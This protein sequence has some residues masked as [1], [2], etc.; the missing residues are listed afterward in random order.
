[1]EKIVIHGGKRL[2]GKIQI[3]GAKNSVLP[4]MAASLLTEEEVVVRNV[5]WLG[6][7]QIMAQIMRC[8][9]CEAEYKNGNLTLRPNAL[10][11]KP[12]AQNQLTNEIRY[13]LHFI[14][15][16]LPR[17]DEV[18][19][20]LPGGCAIGTR[21]LDSHILG[22]TML[23]AK[24]DVG[25]DYIR[26]LKTKLEGSEI[27]LEYP[28]VGATENIIIA[29]CLAEGRTSLE[30]AA[31]EPEIVDLAKFLNSMGARI[32]GAGTDVI[33]IEG[34]TTL[35]GTEYT[36]MPDRIETGTYLVAASVTGGE[37][38]LENT[39]LTVMS[40]VVQKL[41]QIGVQIEGVKGIVRVS[42]SD[43]LKPTDIVTDVYPGFPTDM[44]P[45]VTPLLCL[46]DGEST[47]IERIFDK[48]FNHVPELVKMGAN[49]KIDGNS[50]LVSGV[51]KL[52]GAEV[53]S[54]DIRAGGS[55][56]L[57]A[58]AAHGMTSISGANQVLRGYENLVEKLRNV[59]AELSETS[60]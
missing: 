49:I 9:G 44:Q 59:G 10:S 2:S 29:A 12:L 50:L 36:V 27:A 32:S 41:R 15:A 55:L 45:I 42:S 35:N 23:G 40:S 17:F 6:D 43:K 39:D 22:F 48:R 20:S 13:S 46:A 5:P 16:L 18:I 11:P 8:I 54:L 60:C 4:I 21:K 58:L 56:V 34:V 47:V 51:K 1:M 31:K 37:L 30:N 26:V 57:G 14:G 52:R 38:V 28:S 33:R 3:S 53:N 25:A 7:V 19:V 24:V